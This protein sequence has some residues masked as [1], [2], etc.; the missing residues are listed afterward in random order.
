MET[1]TKSI[2]NKIKG[3]FLTNSIRNRYML[4]I[5]PTIMLV[6]AAADIT[7]FHL[8]KTSNRE[9]TH[10]MAIQTMQ[11]QGYNVENIF[12]SYIN[13]L[14]LMANICG[15]KQYTPQQCVET[16]L[17]MLQGKESTYY[18]IR[19]TTPDGNTYSS[20]S[21]DSLSMKKRKFYKDI[22][23]N[24][25]AFSIE[26]PFYPVEGDTTRCYSVSVP[27]S[28]SKGQTKAA[29]TVLFDINIVNKF[30]EAMK[31][32]GLG[33]GTLVNDEMT[34]TAYPDHSCIM[35]INFLTPG[36]FKFK[37]LDSMGKMLQTKKEG[38]GVYTV[39]AGKTPLLIYYS[40]LPKINWQVGIVIPEPAL[41]ASETKLKILYIFMGF[42]TLILLVIVIMIATRRVVIKPINA[43]NNFTEDFAKGKLYTTATSNIKSHDELGKLNSNIK[44][45]QS[46]VFD[47]VKKIR[48]NCNDIGDT[49]VVLHDSIEKIAYGAKEQAATVEEI[50]AALEEMNTS[51]EQNAC[52]AN[53]TKQS[54]NEMAEGILTVS[55]SSVSTL[56][57]IQNV[58]SKIAIINDISSRTDLLAINAAVEAA[59]AGEN[60]KGF[61]VVA[62]EIRKLAEHC[63]AAST[64]I[65]E[66]SA[67]SLKITEHSA[68]LID[69]ITPKIRKNAEMV[70]EIA[71]S[72][73]EQ[74]NGTSSINNA[75]Q[76]LV[77]ISQSNADLS[78]KMTVYISNLVN[79]IENLSKSVG[80]FKLSSNENSEATNNII[81]EIEKHMS[82]IL[83]L[84]NLL[85]DSTPTDD[86]KTEEKSEPAHAPAATANMPEPSFIKTP[87]ESSPHKPGMHIKLDDDDDSDYENY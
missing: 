84:K 19:C 28:D 20:N 62:A 2:K 11:I 75:L 45:M 41:F 13:Q 34:I 24:H 32:N 87:M 39:Y 35:E 54:S 58:I 6:L 7:I 10:K 17:D 23:Q 50:S 12:T 61:A 70:S 60:G 48:G 16:C 81:R 86:P 15:A 22:F 8:I 27:I 53:M 18:R 80:F 37:G 57:C 40:K 83:K 69:K 29:L 3:M 78:E 55:K 68:E 71:T 4:I 73:T 64:Q 76:Q 21:M 31:I 1:N 72:C 52:N 44:D 46:T 63:Q 85:K 66:W 26:S 38:N 9:A 43:I 49:S 5:I 77:N 59:R 47:A 30:A 14:E 33:N 56:A 65:N 74:L 25:A 36:K 79:K 51:I 67:K 42:V 82:E